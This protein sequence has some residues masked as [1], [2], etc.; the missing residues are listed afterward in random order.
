MVAKVAVKL[1][2]AAEERQEELP[3]PIL[4]KLSRYEQMMEV[5][6]WS[7]RL[8]AR[9]Q[10]RILDLA[11]KI[12][13]W[14]ETLS[15]VPS[16]G[17]AAEHDA[18]LEDMDRSLEEL[19]PEI[20]ELAVVASDHVYFLDRRVAELDKRVGWFSEMLA[21]LEAWKPYRGARRAVN[22]LLDSI[23]TKPTST[24]TKQT[25]ER[26]LTVDHLFLENFEKDMNVRNEGSPMAVYDDWVTMYR[27]G[28]RAYGSQQ[29]LYT[30]I[31]PRLINLH[32]VVSFRDKKV[33]ELGPFEGANTK[34]IVDLGASKVVAIEANRDAFI[35][36]MAVKE[37]FKLNNLE[38][39]YDDFTQLITDEQFL[40]QHSFDI[41]F[42]AGVL[43]HMH[44]PLETIANICKVAPIVYVHTHIASH[45]VPKGDWVTLKDA[46]G[47]EYR[48]R[49]NHYPK[50]AHWGG[51]E[52]YAIWL[53]EE[54][55]LRAFR[56]QGCEISD[57]YVGRNEIRGD[58]ISFVATRKES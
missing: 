20:V 21:K 52:T 8:D 16:E 25:D 28:A 56:N 17:P 39:I 23:G 55:M 29:P 53:E 3:A 11:E 50:K 42:A 49:K 30:D 33:V 10:E 2:D 24:E 47:E 12:E 13:T 6:S 14:K 31:D 27:K 36:C 15:N 4:R 19:M 45:K 44:Q 40:E 18:L 58:Y 54:A 57:V 51:V 46:N 9:L 1:T 7:N 5:T 34:Q 32:G 22:Y 35:K 48:G 26:R 43:Y 37:T 38:L 41:C